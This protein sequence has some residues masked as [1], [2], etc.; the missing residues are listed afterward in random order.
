MV[1]YPKFIARV[2]CGFSRKGMQKH[3][4]IV[5]SHKRVYTTPEVKTP[6]KKRRS[7]KKKRRKR[8]RNRDNPNHE[9]ATLLGISVNTV[10]LS[11][12][13]EELQGEKEEKYDLMSH[14]SHA[15]HLALVKATDY[16]RGLPQDLTMQ[17][18]PFDRK[19]K[20]VRDIDVSALPKKIPNMFRYR[21]SRTPVRTLGHCMHQH[22]CANDVMNDGVVYMTIATLSHIWFCLTSTILV[23]STTRMTSTPQ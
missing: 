8:R 2:L 11:D 7:K 21:F 17:L 16:A 9:T 23:I 15:L 22:I 12:D 10:L 14:T 20:G 1:S 18:G 6:G 5:C 4:G 13:D 3:T 19:H